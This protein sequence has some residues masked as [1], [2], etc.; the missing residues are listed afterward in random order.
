M[1]VP[2][3]PTRG[4]TL[5]HAAFVHDL[6]DP[7]LLMGKRADYD[8][9]ILQL[10]QLR[11]SDR[12]LDLGCG[13]GVLTR[14]IADRLSVKAGGYA[15]G[16]DAAGR[17]IRLA[18]RSRGGERCRFEP[19]AAEELPFRDESFDAVVSSL[20]FHHVQLDLKRKAF[21][22][23]FRVLR[24]GG[25][26]VVAD[27]H[28]PTTWMGSLVSHTARWFFLQPAISEN[29]RGVLPEIMVEAGFP[30]PVH[31]CTLFGYVALFKTEKPLMAA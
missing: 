14:M 15:M 12:V 31:V 10:L 9:L 4:R 6:T 11:D 26:L 2:S 23:A 1:K 5:D 30:P 29:I 13:T 28:I 17:M 18:R 20:F 16:I 21:Q 27:M 25:R 19:A 22:E 24:P 7:L 8:R 3:V